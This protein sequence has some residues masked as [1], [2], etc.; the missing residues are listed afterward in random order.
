MGRMPVV[1][2][3]RVQVLQR[4][5]GTRSHTIVWPSGAVHEEADR[6]LRTLELGTDRTYAYLLVDHL[7]WLV[8]AC[9]RN[10]CRCRIWSGTWGR[11]ARR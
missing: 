6:F 9:H 8:S 4:G 1:G 7:R 5:D 2:E 3:L 10:R 11:S